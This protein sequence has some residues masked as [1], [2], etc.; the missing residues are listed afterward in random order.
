M[1]KRLIPLFILLCLLGSCAPAPASP[2]S[3][4][5]ATISPTRTPRPTQTTIPTATPYPPLQTEGPYLFYSDGYS[6]LTLMD[7]D[8]SGREQFQLPNNGRIGWYL[9]NTVS[10]NGEWLAYYTGSVEQPYDLALHLFNIS[11]KNSQIVS[12]LIAPGYPENLEPVT[13]ILNFPDY[14]A[15]CER[16]LQCQLFRVQSSFEGIVHSIDW[17]PDSKFLAFAAQ[18]DGP[19]SDIYIFNTEDSS[20]R[21]LTDELENI[22]SIDWSPNGEKI[23]YEDSIMGDT[24]LSR[25]IRIADPNIKSSQHPE[26]IDGGG[27]WFSYGWIDQNSYLIYNG[28]EGAPPHRLR[29]I[30][31]KTKEVREIW[32]Y[33]AESFFVDIENQLIVLSPYGTMWL[34]E[35]PEPGIYIL[36]FSGEYKKISDEVVRIIEEQD[37]INQYISIQNYNELVSIKVDGSLTSLSR[38]PDYLVPPRVSP[39]GKWIVITNETETELYSDDLQLIKSLGFHAVEII[40]RPDSAGVFLFSDPILYS[41]P[42]FYY[43]PVS[44]ENPELIEVCASGN[45]RPEEYI[46]LP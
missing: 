43:L 15:E 23:L 32:K 3:T 39:D 44:N 25:Y 22:W 46:W 40:W 28:G 10:P 1:T 11:S 33:S 16:D 18:I 5:T 31:V 24:Y 14:D 12:N 17:S 29:I 9:E 21:R 4:P 2:T 13:K 27:F 6:T 19:S 7:A 41:E 36:S 45:C 8:G 34:E 20:I 35:E 38:K 30:N 37:T 42:K 26:A